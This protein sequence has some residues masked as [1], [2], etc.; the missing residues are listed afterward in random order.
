MSGNMANA[1]LA[2]DTISDIALKTRIAQRLCAA[3]RQKPQQRMWPALGDIDVCVC[4]KDCA[5]QDVGREQVEVCC[6]AADDART[7]R[8]RHQGLV[9][10]VYIHAG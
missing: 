5:N 3:S 2:C 1:R 4:G 8:T 9:C 10:V 6:V 7:P